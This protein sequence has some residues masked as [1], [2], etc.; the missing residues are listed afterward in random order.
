MRLLRK[1]VKNICGLLKGSQVKV[2]RREE[3]ARNIY[4][5]LLRWNLSLALARLREEVP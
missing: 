1:P 5:W 2:T 3:E 4:T